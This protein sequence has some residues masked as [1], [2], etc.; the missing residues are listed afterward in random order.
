MDIVLRSNMFYFNR[1]LFERMLRRWF[2][3]KLTLFSALSTV[4]LSLV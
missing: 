1:I 3:D 2:F 4:A